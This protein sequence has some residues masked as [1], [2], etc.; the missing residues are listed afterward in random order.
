MYK[1]KGLYL[2][3]VKVTKDKGFRNHLRFR[4]QR[5]KET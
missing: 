5:L 1:I 4:D 3:N 2:K